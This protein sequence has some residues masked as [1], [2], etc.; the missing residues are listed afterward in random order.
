MATGTGSGSPLAH[1]ALRAKSVQRTR[2]SLGMSDVGPNAGNVRPATPPPTAPAASSP[3]AN[4]AAPG[5]D[6]NSREALLARTQEM[7]NQAAA[8]GQQAPAPPA[9]Q[10]PVAPTPEPLDTRLAQ[11]GAANLP[12]QTQFQRLAG[13]P[14][15][16]RDL[17]VYASYR[18]LTTE[19]GRPPTR[20]ELAYRLTANPGAANMGPVV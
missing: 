19:L 13:R 7:L 1:V 3:A 12:L 16:S 4:P 20:T 11:L 5:G 2:A 17:V 8:G 6:P 14:G 9:I 18:Q 10:T 15:T